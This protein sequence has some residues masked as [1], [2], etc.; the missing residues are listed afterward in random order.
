MTKILGE[1]NGNYYILTIDGKNELVEEVNR[2]RFYNQN[3]EYNDSDF[4]SI[5]EFIVR[6]FD[7]QLENALGENVKPNAI[8]LDRHFR[9][10]ENRRKL[11][12]WFE[13]VASSCNREDLT[14]DDILSY[15][16]SEEYQH[17][18]TNNGF[19]ATISGMTEILKRNI[20]L[21][22]IDFLDKIKSNNSKHIKR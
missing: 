5:L 10:S 6:N 4:L 12:T 2:R 14:G 1:F 13:S 17:G 18:I 20:G 11:E 9:I 3:K 19:I 7:N 16:C 21:D 8:P 15:F 22:N